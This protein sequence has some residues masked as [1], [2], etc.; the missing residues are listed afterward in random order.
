M[1]GGR[2]GDDGAGDGRRGAG[3]VVVLEFGEELAGGAGSAAEL[4]DGVVEE[5]FL[6]ALGGD[7]LS[8]G[9]L[10]AEAAAE[11]VE[12]AVLAE[13]FV[14]LAHGDAG[15]AAD[16]G[17]EEGVVAA[18]EE[19]LLP[20]LGAGLVEVLEGLDLVFGLGLEAE[21]VADVAAG[22]LEAEAG[23][24]VLADAEGV[25]HLA[26]GVL[27]EVEAAAAVGEAR[28]GPEGALELR[29]PD[30]LEAR[31]AHVAADARDD[32]H[33]RVGA[34][35][36]AEAVVPLDRPAREHRLRAER[37]AHHL[38]PLHLHRGGRRRHHRPAHGLGL[39]AFRV[40]SEELPMRHDS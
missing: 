37:P 6:D 17:G 2:R 26:G 3:G 13:L 24:D 8:V 39:H 5:G 31:Q 19:G 25:R 16:E 11:A 29:A 28:L 32:E 36:G 38:R 12:E 4:F 23:V 15:D 30:A 22:P 10:E 40:L 20:G 35:A 7:N 21:E 27:A 18:G 1:L 33:G 9:V 34:L 14:E